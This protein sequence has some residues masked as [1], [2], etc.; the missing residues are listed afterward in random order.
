M[1]NHMTTGAVIAFAIKQPA[2]ALPLAFLSHF[3]LDALPHYGQQG[4]EHTFSKLTRFIVITDLLVA[5]SFLLWL[6]F[7]G[8]YVAAAGAF[9]AASPD[10]A[11]AY[12]ITYLHIVGVIPKPSLLTRFHTWIQWGERPWGL[13]IELVYTISI[14]L[15]LRGF[16]S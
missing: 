12:R 2:F 7:S 13:A 4:E 1:T 15:V 16:A 5:G 9:L 3:L 6:I 10:A 8:Y 14:L 11:W